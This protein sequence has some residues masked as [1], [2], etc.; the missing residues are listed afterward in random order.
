MAD[1]VLIEKL[2]KF[3]LSRQES[4]IYLCLYR[5]GAMTG[6]ETAKLTGI[7]RSNVYSAIAGLVE[8]G[9]VHLLDGTASKYIVVGLEEYTADYLKHLEEDRVILLENAPSQMVVQEGYLTISGYRHILDKIHHMFEETEYRAYLSASEETVTLFAEDIAMLVKKKLKFVIMTDGYEKLRKKLGY[10]LSQEE[11]DTI[12]RYQTEQKATQLRLI[13]DSK[14][15]LTGE[16]KGTRADTALYSAQ[17]N[18]VNVFKE[19]L[20][21]EIELIKIRENSG[22]SQQKTEKQGR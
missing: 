18:F 12:I 8:H 1:E 10:Y 7:S 9:A 15:V 3:G 22:K 20:H 11:Y 13:I 6:Y 14:Y 5:N 21:N 19:A 17:A 4:I 2:M 16:L